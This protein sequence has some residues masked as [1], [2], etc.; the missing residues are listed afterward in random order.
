MTLLP[1]FRQ[2]FGVPP[3]VSADAPGRVNLIGEHT[4]YNDGFVLPAAI[5]QRTRVEAA[6]RDDL[7]VRLRSAEFPDAPVE[8]TLG[9]EHDRG[10][11]GWADYIKGMTLVLAEYGLRRGFDARIES[12]VPV[13]SGLSSSAALEISAG[14]ALRAL[15][16]LPIDD[17]TLAR[18]GQRAENEFVGAPVGIMDQMAA[19]LADA[20][21]AL[22][23]DT[24]SLAYSRV[25]LPACGALIVI[26]SGIRHQHAGGEYG[27][28]RAECAEAARQLGVAALRDVDDVR[29]VESLPPPLNRRA[30]HV[31][32]ENRR[33]LDA[34]DALRSDDCVRAGQLFRESHASMRD[35]FEISIE[36]V[37]RLVEIAGAV[38]GV[39]GARMTGG[40]FGGA[41]VALA[42]A[43]TARRTADEIVARYV[44][45]TGHPGKR[46]VPE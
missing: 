4:D 37:D 6:A 9:R 1:P 40:G 24:R 15:F 45:K 19:S 11:S 43:A 13:G 28:R 31:V 36:P 42:D 29:R 16:A 20:A 8:F 23:L 10:A 22:F 30:R 34:V 3:Q 18:A 21:A 26:D 17:V 2:I 14:R 5:P 39:Y 33:V 44:A 7:T 12:D 32:R 38:Q 27:I 41:I 46:L 25:P 35:D